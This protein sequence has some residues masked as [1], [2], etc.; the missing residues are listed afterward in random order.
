MRNNPITA[1]LKEVQQRR[2][3]VALYTGTVGE[4]PPELLDRGC[5]RRGLR[6][7]AISDAPL[8]DM[9]VDEAREA[10]RHAMREYVA[11]P[12]P[13]GI[14]LIKVTPGVGKTTAAVALAEYLAEMGLRVLYAAPR[15]NFFLDVIKIAK[16]PEWWYEWLPRQAGDPETGEG[17]TCLHSDKMQTWLHRGYPAI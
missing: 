14:L 5:I 1:W 8:P 11:D 17:Q 16:H 10:I 6:P 7:A 4:A 13:E 9:T 2:E 3:R 15:H 12:S